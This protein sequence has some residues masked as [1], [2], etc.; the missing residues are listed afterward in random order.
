MYALLKIFVKISHQ[1]SEISQFFFILRDYFTKI[2]EQYLLLVFEKFH[3]IEI[4]Q[5]NSEK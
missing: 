1:M 5:R 3:K 2:I 4:N